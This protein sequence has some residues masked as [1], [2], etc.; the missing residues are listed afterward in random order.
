MPMSRAVVGLLSPETV[1]SACVA[2]ERDDGWAAAVVTKNRDP[3]S[4]ARSG[5]TG[6]VLRRVEADR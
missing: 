3:A 4:M 5:G 2:V 1:V 6:G